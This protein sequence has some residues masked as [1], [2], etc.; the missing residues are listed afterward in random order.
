MWGFCTN[1]WLCKLW[2]PVK[3]PGLHLLVPKNWI[4]A[5]G[6]GKRPALGWMTVQ[7]SWAR[8]MFSASPLRRGERG[9]QPCWV[10]LPLLSSLY[11]EGSDAPVF[12]YPQEQIVQQ[13][14]NT[15]GS[16]LQCRDN[17]EKIT[18]AQL[19]CSIGDLSAWYLPP[20]KFYTQKSNNCIFLFFLEWKMV[21]YYYYNYYYFTNLVR[22]MM[23]VVFYQKVLQ[24]AAPS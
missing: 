5:S 23:I 6:M 7:Q 8:V 4:H 9:G 1:K 3:Q 17:A 18:R 11:L 22:T 12:I 16:Y 24:L 19:C 13:S 20:N 15:S 21:Y 10:N 14:G 2:N